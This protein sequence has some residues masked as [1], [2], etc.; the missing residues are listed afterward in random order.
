[1]DFVFFEFFNSNIF[2]SIILI[3]LEKFRVIIVIFIIISIVKFDS[4]I[5]FIGGENDFN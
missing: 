5:S 1:M 3:F 4:W 2:R